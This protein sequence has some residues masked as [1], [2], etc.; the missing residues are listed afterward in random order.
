MADLPLPAA[1]STPGAGGWVPAKAVQVG[2]STVVACLGG[3][4]QYLGTVDDS[5]PFSWRTAV[6]A[7]SMAAMGYLATFFGIGSAG[8]RK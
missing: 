6:S 5:H 7:C 8:P 2:L 3:V 4:G 1:A